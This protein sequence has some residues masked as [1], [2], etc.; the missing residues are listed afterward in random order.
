M[1]GEHEPTVPRFRPL[2]KIAP[3]EQVMLAIAAP[4][5]WLIA[6]VV[7][8]TVLEDTDAIE[9]GL[10]IAAGSFLVALA[11]L[12]LLRAGRRRQERRFDGR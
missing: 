6:F 5:L 7:T 3:L 11:V 12:I 1:T 2:G 9:L 8:S 4:L 10:L